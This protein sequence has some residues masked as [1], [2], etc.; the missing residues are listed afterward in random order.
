MKKLRRLVFKSYLDDGE[1]ILD[2]AHTHIIKFKIQASKISFFGIFVPV[3]LYILFPVKQVFFISLVWAVIG[4]GAFFY[5]FLDWYYDVWLLTNV[6]V[7]SIHRNGLFDVTTQKVDYY[8]ITD[9]TYTVKGVLQTLLNFGDITIDR[10]S[11]NV[12]M[13]LKD[14]SNPKGLEKKITEYRDRYVTDKS[15]HDHH[16]LKNM[17]ADMIAYHANNGKIEIPKDK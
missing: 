17:L 7:I 6:G 4:I 3:L 14:A 12:V 8:M 9:V 5:K 15:F 16:T 2:V 11:A 10:M 13:T 1:R